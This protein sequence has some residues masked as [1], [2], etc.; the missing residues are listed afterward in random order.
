MASI[1]AAKIA[2]AFP[3]IAVDVIRGRLQMAKEL[4]ATHGFNARKTKVSEA[5]RSVV[6]AGVDFA[7]ET[8]GTKE[9]FQQALESLANRGTCGRVAGGSNPER[10]LD[11]RQLIGRGRRVLGIVEGDAVPKNFINRS[12]RFH[13]IR[14]F[15]I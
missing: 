14:G 3:I 12:L 7:L 10:T 9:A 15:P 8:T 4:G 13:N 1:M 5:I 11:M 2:G 6:A